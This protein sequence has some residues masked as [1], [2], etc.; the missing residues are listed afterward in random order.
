MRIGLSYTGD[1][2]KHQNYVNWLRGDDDIEIVRLSAAED[3]GT[4]LGDCDALVLS[5]GIDINPELAR[6]QNDYAN[7]PEQWQPERDLFEKS[8]YEYAIQNNMPVLGICRGMQLVNVLQGGTLVDDLDARNETHKKEGNTDKAHPV[9]IRENTL[10][11]EI[12]NTQSG[13]INSAHHQAIRELG[14]NL[15]VNSLAD[16]GTIEGIEWKDKSGKP[17]MICVQWHP[18]RMFGFPDSPMSKNIRDRFIE[19]A[20]RPKTARHEYH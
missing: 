3:N 9:T 4:E 16:D 5:G 12:V 8:L 10:L 7:K 13:D 17:F 15:Q 19:E 14:E 20:K 1:A 18:E 11:G 2:A 6:G